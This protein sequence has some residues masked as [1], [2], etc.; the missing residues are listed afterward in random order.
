MWVKAKNAVAA[1]VGEETRGTPRPQAGKATAG[2]GVVGGGQ[3]KQ[4]RLSGKEVIAMNSLDNE[5]WTMN[6]YTYRA[7]HQ[8]GPGGNHQTLTATQSARR[9]QAKLANPARVGKEQQKKGEGKSNGRRTTAPH[10]KGRATSPPPR[11]K[12]TNPPQH[13]GPQRAPGRASKTT[14]E[15]DEATPQHRHRPA[16]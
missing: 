13:N 8:K 5:F 6:F 2:R 16:E 10:G 3:G 9:T 1:V 7:R 12:P 11:A 4:L 15:G 14:G